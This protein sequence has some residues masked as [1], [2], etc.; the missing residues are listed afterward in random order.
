[1]IAEIAFAV[2]KRLWPFLLAGGIIAVEEVRL[3]SAHHSL[4]V[5]RKRETVLQSKLDVARQRATDLAL[6]YADQLP[7]IDAA[8]RQQE[9]TDRVRMDSL[10]DRIDALSRELDVRISADAR[11]VLDDV[12]AVANGRDAAAAAQPAE[13]AAAVPAVPEAISEHDLVE[14]AAVAGE[15]YLSCVRMFHETRDIYNAARNAQLKVNP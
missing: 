8:A 1:M 2:L 15:A 10:N 3:S 4:D 12:T 14:Y 5:S 7:K 11:R 13:G 6:L 9:A